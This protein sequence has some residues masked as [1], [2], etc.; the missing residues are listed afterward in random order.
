MPAL[1]LRNIFL[2][3]AFSVLNLLPLHAQAEGGIILGGTRLVYPAQQ[4]ESSITVQNTSKTDRYMVQSWI[5]DRNGNK[6]ND[7]IATPPIF[8][9]NPGNENT[10]R[11]MFAGPSLPADRESLYYLTSKAI[12]AVDK[13]KAVDKNI[14]VLAAATRIKL[15]VRPAGLQPSPAEA[16]SKLTFS[17]SDRKII[18]SNPTPYYITLIDIK[19]DGKEQNNAVMVPPLGSETL[20]LSQVQVKNITYKTINDY[21]GLDKELS[22]KF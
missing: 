19:V 7:F 12:P 3:S 18:I 14:L 1:S 17:N 22:W 13:H 10:L 15:F 16:P 9:S 2:V 20:P 4:K 6:T 21:G 8:V 5:E 11:V